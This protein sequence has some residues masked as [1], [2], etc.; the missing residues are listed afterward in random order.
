MIESTTMSVATHPKASV[1]VTVYCPP[2]V[3]VNPT[4]LVTPLFQV[5]VAAPVP[6][7]VAVPPGHTEKSGPALTGGNAFPVTI[8]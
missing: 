5:Y 1:P 8:T 2:V 6:D 4:P 3:S 7:K